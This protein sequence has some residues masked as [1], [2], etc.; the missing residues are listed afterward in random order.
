[1][2][3][4]SPNLVCSS[5]IL[6]LFMLVPFQNVFIAV[7]FFHF[8][9]F[10]VGNSVPQKAFG[11]NERFQ[12]INPIRRLSFEVKV[13]FPWALISYL[14]SFK[15]D[16]LFCLWLFCGQIVGTSVGCVTG[17]HGIFFSSLKSKDFFYY[18]KIC[19]KINW[20]RENEK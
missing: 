8:V 11:E 19:L 6:I 13:R 5:L 10:F 16:E 7:Y 18:M 4:S 17:S 15:C 2:P 1:M 9:G 12:R 3:Q 14:S 20:L